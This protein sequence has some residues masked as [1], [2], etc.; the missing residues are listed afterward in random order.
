MSDV[1]AERELTVDGRPAV[2]RLY[3]PETVGRE[4]RC[5]ATI[6][7][8]PDTD[9]DQTF[10]VYGEDTLQALLLALEPVRAWLSGYDDVAWQGQPGTGLPEPD[11]DSDDEPPAADG[12]PALW[13]V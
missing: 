9:G 6:S 7:G 4:A 12:G 1:I 13:T 2:I 5:R 10:T 8:L 11:E 3:A